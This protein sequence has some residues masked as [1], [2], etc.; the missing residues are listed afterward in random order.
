MARTMPESAN[1]HSRGH[2]EDEQWHLERDL[3][4]IRQSLG[5]RQSLI[6][7]GVPGHCPRSGWLVNGPGSWGGQR[8]SGLVVQIGEQRRNM[9][10]QV[11]WN[12]GE[13]VRSGLLQPEFHH[14]FLLRGSCLW[15]CVDLSPQKGGWNATSPCSS[16][17][18]GV[19]MQLR[20][21]YN[22]WGLFSEPTL[23]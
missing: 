4:Q 20:L 12:H 5:V 16:L 2:T 9:I 15:V 21:G 10:V 17:G 7:C 19:H 6:P 13:P 14:F 11:L 3:S 1:A 18:S 8:V 23:S 22:S